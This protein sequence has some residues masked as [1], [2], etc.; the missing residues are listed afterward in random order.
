MLDSRNTGDSAT[1][2]HFF[3]YG[4]NLAELVKIVS[5]CLNLGLVVFGGRV[6]AYF[7]RFKDALI[8]SYKARVQNTFGLEVANLS[9]PKFRVAQLKYP[10]LVGA[11][12]LC[13][14]NI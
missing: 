5:G 2:L 8:D 13:D 3:N 4:R 6:S 11:A 10:V 1:S 9:M 12:A 7:D 14:A